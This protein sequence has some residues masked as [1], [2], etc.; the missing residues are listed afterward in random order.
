ML[1]REQR[2][3][4]D[5]MMRMLRDGCEVSVLREGPQAYS[6]VI[7]DGKAFWIGHAILASAAINRAIV[8]WEKRS[9]RV[10]KRSTRRLTS[11]IYGNQCRRKLASRR[12][13]D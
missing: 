7:S 3:A 13:R 12:T 2:R 10:K 1:K 9:E 6:A 5:A 8:D 4:V 11:G